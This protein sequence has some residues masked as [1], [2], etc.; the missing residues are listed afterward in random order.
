[1]HRV[2]TRLRTNRPF[3]MTWIRWMLG[4]NCRL[5]AFIEWLRLLPDMGF[6]PHISHFAIA[7][8]SFVGVND[9]ESCL[10]DATIAIQL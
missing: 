4:L 2:Q 5:V 7:S 10:L 8:T 9:L 3:S 1:M 6:L